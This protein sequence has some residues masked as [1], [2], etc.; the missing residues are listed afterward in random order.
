V[1]RTNG[2]D[3]PERS[4]FEI[5]DEII[6]AISAAK[7]ISTFDNILK[8]LGDLDDLR[9]L[10]RERNVFGNDI[11][12]DVKMIET[13]MLD[14]IIQ[15]VGLMDAFADKEDMTPK[16]HELVAEMREKLTA[17]VEERR[18]M[19]INDARR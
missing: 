3:Q 10:V 11:F 5:T 9:V 6:V 15:V 8:A 18:Q 13:T 16:E 14:S 2:Q 19:I 4:V 12:S 17:K 1:S 7:I